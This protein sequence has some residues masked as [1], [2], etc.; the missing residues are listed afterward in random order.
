MR[1]KFQKAIGIKI[2][3]SQMVETLHPQGP[4]PVG[5]EEPLSSGA[6]GATPKGLV[7]D[8]RRTL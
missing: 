7:V 8:V 6:T 2:M 5:W 4:D 3:S 1:T